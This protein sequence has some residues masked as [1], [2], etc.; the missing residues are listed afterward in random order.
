MALLRDIVN[1]FF[2]KTEKGNKSAPCPG[3]GTLP[4]L[5]GMFGHP[6]VIHYNLNYNLNSVN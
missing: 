4:Y 2:G 3:K 5:R 1:V 6:R